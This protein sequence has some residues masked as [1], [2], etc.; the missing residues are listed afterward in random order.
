MP[1]LP[2]FQY[3]RVGAII[4]RGMSHPHA[5]A[6]DYAARPLWWALALTLGFAAVEAVS[7]W[8]ANSLALIGDAGHMF[9][10]AVALALAATAMWFG[11]RP[12]S[13]RH[14]YG[15]VR[16]E[17]IAALFNGLLML[18]VVVGIVIEALQRL[19]ATESSSVAGGTVTVVALVGLAINGAV[20]LMLS[21]GRDNLGTRAALLHV[22]GDLF[23]SVAAVIAGVVIFFTGWTPIDPILSLLICILIL[24]STLRLLREVLHV[25]MEG[26]PRHLDLN[27][28]GLSLAKV[29]GVNSIHDLHIWTLASGMPALSAHVVL[30]DMSSWDTVFREIRSLLHKRYAIEHVTLQPEL[31]P[32]L[33]PGRSAVIEIFPK[34]E[35]HADGAQKS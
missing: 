6:L 2:S 24:Y 20:A 15:L 18:I 7:G 27:A 25:L 28:V 22:L 5:H 31:L 23:G 8:W 30:T 3:Y 21:R 10:D 17:M 16:T 29:Q 11:R 14:S 35:K 9:S 34:T 26:V 13:A 1:I 32:P 33:P 4:P 19:R 12:P